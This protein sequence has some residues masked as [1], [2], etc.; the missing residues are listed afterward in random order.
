MHDLVLHLI[1]SH[2]GHCRPFAPV[3]FDEQVVDVDSSCAVNERIGA[4]L[5]ILSV[6]ILASQT[7][8]GGWCGAMAG[9]VWLGW[10][11]CCGSLIGGRANGEE[12][13]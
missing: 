5:L 12:T 11:R 1:A 8:I 9:G 10:K 6:S 3:I 2:H 4:V 7:A 13:Q